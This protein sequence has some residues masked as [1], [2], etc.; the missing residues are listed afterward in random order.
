ML[1]E[2]VTVPNV[3]YA[4]TVCESI[5]EVFLEKYKTPFKVIRNVPFKQKSHPGFQKPTKKIVLYQ[6]ALNEGR[7]LEE[8]ILAMQSVENAELWLVGEGDLSQKLRDLTTR[9]H[10]QN[11]VIFKGYLTPIQLKSITPMASVGLNLLQ[12]KG[13]SYYYS[14]ANKA[15]DYIQA[16][17]PA[18]NMNFP[19][20]QKLNT[21]F[22][23]SILLDDIEPPLIAKTLN[24][25]LTNEKLYATLQANCK[26]ASEVYIWEEEQKKL[27]EFYE[28]VFLTV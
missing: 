14:L 8:T 25:L 26:L 1:I 2:Q 23:T 21:A 18:I 4:Y 13:L 27:I 17:V 5:A 3:K 10:L 22:E 7:G 19:E 15:F 6:G 11:K 16:Q 20:Y 24:L 12:N 28:K 9:L